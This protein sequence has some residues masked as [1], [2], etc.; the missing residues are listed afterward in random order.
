MWGGGPSLE[1]EPESGKLSKLTSNNF[2][3]NNLYLFLLNIFSFHAKFVLFFCPKS[4]DM[5]LHAFTP[6]NVAVSEVSYISSSI[7]GADAVNTVTKPGI[8]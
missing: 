5:C 4:G 8:I 2:F 7:N 6:L 3:Q 1:K